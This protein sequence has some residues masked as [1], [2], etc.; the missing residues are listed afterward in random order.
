[1][2]EVS[3]APCSSIASISSNMFS[4]SDVADSDW[5]AMVTTVGRLRSRWEATVRGPDVER[6]DEL[7]ADVASSPVNL[8]CSSSPESES[9]VRSMTT[10]RE[11][12]GTAFRRRLTS[13]GRELLAPEA[14]PL[15]FDVIFEVST[16]RDETAMLL[17]R[18][19]ELIFA[20]CTKFRVTRVSED[21]SI[22][23]VRSAT[24]SALSTEAGRFPFSCRE[25]RLKRRRS[26][27]GRCERVFA[28]QVMERLGGTGYQ[29]PIQV[30]HPAT[31]RL[32]SMV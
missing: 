8:S 15:L 25:T 28:I 2:S 5:L 23:G 3:S 19:I 16:E 7:A 11:G 24:P 31:E 32:K 6:E 1:M 9:T 30:V 21:L 4:S 27:W 20:T 12:F 18:F 14:D 13:S 17:L 22:F 29:R 10:G 26:R